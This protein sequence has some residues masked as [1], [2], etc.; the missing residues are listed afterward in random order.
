MDIR[1]RKDFITKGRI[2]ICRTPALKRYIGDITNSK[3]WPYYFILYSSSNQLLHRIEN[4]LYEVPAGQLLFLGPDRFH[5][6]VTGQSSDFWVVVFDYGFYART[7]NDAY[8]IQNSK[9]FYDLGNIYLSKPSID[10]S[11]YVEL[12]M[13]F[14]EEL[15]SRHLTPI[16]QD[17]LHNAVQSSLLRSTFFHQ[18]IHNPEVHFANNSDRELANKFRELLHIHYQQEKKIDYYA[19]SLKTTKRRLNNAIA[20]IYGRSAKQLIIEKIFEESKNLL[21]HS[22][23]SIKEISY[24]MGFTEENNFS[25]FFKK[26]AGCSPK[27]YKAILVNLSSK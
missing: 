8:L 10:V 7:P 18:G 4:E 21:A 3:R 23:L 12:Q 13:E 6:F 11:A 9:L 22:L 20:S 27:K 16:V 1:E 2:H 17:I 26:H 5:S 25:T 15:A 14:L 19:N 24:E